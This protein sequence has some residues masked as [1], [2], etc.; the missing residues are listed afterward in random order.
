[1]VIIISTKYLAST[2]KQAILNNCKQFNLIPHTS[3]IVFSRL[4]GIVAEGIHV[5]ERGLQKNET[6]TFNP[7]QMYKLMEFLE[8]LPEQPIV[9]DFSQYTDSECSIKLT[10]FEHRF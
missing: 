3:E 6:C 5:L 10:Q 2:I 1:M 8:Q 9:I 7:I 4:S